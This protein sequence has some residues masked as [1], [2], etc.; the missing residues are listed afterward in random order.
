MGRYWRRAKP[1]RRPGNAL[2]PGWGN[3]NRD[4]QPCPTL[5]LARSGRA[6]ANF[7]RDP[8]QRYQPSRRSRDSTSR[9]KNK[10]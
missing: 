4:P 5:Q 2:G 7:L 6:Q 1:R 3:L 8:P 9:H 10:H